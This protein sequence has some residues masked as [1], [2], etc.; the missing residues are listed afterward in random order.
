MDSGVTGIVKG[1]GRVIGG[2][3]P[4]ELEEMS[5]FWRVGRGGR[6]RGRFFGGSFR[7]PLD[8]GVV[9][10]SVNRSLLSM[11]VSLSLSSSTK[12]SSSSSTD[13]GVSLAPRPLSP[14]LEFLPLLLSSSFVSHHLE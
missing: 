14:P 4:Q 12:T 1:A 2:L 6:L 10:L 7:P 11:F 9:K 13:D 3:D 8:G 5:G